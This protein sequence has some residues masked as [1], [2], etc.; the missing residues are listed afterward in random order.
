[1]PHVCESAATGKVERQVAM[2]TG[3]SRGIGLAIA[4]ALVAD[5]V[6]VAITGLSEAHLSAARPRDRERGARRA[7]RR[8]RPTCAAT[9]T[10]SGRSPPTVARFGGLDILINNAGVG[11]FAERRRHDA[12]AVV[13]GDRHEP[14]RRL[15]RVP[16]GHSA[17]APARRRLHHQHQ[18]PGRERT[19]FAGGAAYCASKSGLER[20]QRSADAGSPLRRHPRELRHARARWRPDSSGGDERRAPTGKSRPKKSRKSSSTCCASG[21]QPAEPRRAAARRSRPK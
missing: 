21:A 20:L 1:M 7:S 15:Q 9:T 19:R 4:R 8:C 17:P 18:Q 11:I 12:R 6:Q 3:G 10:S 5:G 13:G 14:H 16:R 2:V